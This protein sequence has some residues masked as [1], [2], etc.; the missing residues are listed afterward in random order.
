MCEFTAK[1]GDLSV[2]FTP[3]T[4]AQQGIAGHHILAARRG[5]DYQREI[6]LTGRYGALIVRG[7]ADGY[8]PERQ[9][10][11]E[12]KTHRGDLSR[13]PA[14]QRGLH[15][16]QLKIYGALLCVERSL[17]ELDLALV[18]FDIK[19]EEETAL[20]EHYT[21]AELQS[22]FEDHCRRFLDWAMCEMAHRARRDEFLVALTFP[23]EALRAGQ[24]Q[25]AEAVY[26][27]AVGGRALMA[28]APTGIGKTIGTL[29]PLLKAAPKQKLDKV[30]FLVAKTSGRMLALDA[31]RQLAPAQLAPAQSECDAGAEVP[32]R[33]LEPPLRTL[34]M[35]AKESACEYPGRACEAAS[36]PLARGFYDRLASARAQALESAMLDREG[37]RRVALEHQVCPYYLTQEL[38]RWCDVLVGDYNYFFDTSAILHALTAQNQWR[39]GLLVDEA[40]NLLTRARDMYSATLDPAGLEAA[41][42]G[43]PAAI[44]AQLRDVQR[45]WRA[46]HGVQIE[47]Y[48]VHAEI[49]VAFIAALQRATT[50]IADD[51][52]VDPAT[53]NEPLLRFY[54]DAIHFCRTAEEFGSHSLFDVTQAGADSTMCIRNVNPGP[55]LSARFG[56]CVTSTLFS[57]TLA[58][59]AYYRQLLGLPDN[60]EWINVDSPFHERQLHVRVEPRIS[61]RYRD[62]PDSVAPIVELMAQQYRAEPGNYLAFFSSFDYLQAVLRVFGARH[63]DI[64]TWEQVRGMAGADRNAFLARFTTHSRGIGFAVLGG[65]F[66]EGIDLPGERL[67]GAFIATLGLPQVN[68]VNAEIERRLETLFGS[69]YEYTY[70][71]PG[72]QKVIQAAGRVIRTTSDRGTVFLI[73]D[74]YMGA[75]VRALLPEWWRVQCN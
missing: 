7:R 4:T 13:M 38:A 63:P 69:G 48:A 23:H 70:L 45:A 10:L 71:Y 8:D 32:L 27:A 56:A 21:A 6:A 68:D 28:Q 72:L 46:I 50:L 24:R 74:R 20:A 59:Q 37:V 75:Q 26:R 47:D 16:A 5:A 54:F 3:V 52:A 73:D 19:S 60:T 62:R 17:T 61:T 1:S 67:I 22:H 51:M 33:T 31:V 36:C 44:K 29:F 57:A 43:A 53:V 42:T 18:Y 41:H 34:E 64:M 40:H 39:V 35:V 30:F 58:P 49:P 55:F 66:A 15:W 11:E 25:M 65:A 2:R 14:N 12:F 9:V